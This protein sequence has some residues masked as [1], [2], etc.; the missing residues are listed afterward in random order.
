[1]LYETRELLERDVSVEK[2]SVLD[3][4]LQQFVLLGFGEVKASLLAESAQ[5]DLGRV[6][7][8]VKAGCSLDTVMRIVL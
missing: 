7:E 8:L 4:R 5:V 6:R 1:M 3:W 2:Q